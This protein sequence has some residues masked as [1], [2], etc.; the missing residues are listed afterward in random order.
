MGFADLY[1]PGPSTYSDNQQAIWLNCY[2]EDCTY[3]IYYTEK[4]AY[5]NVPNCY[6]NTH[7]SRPRQNS[8]AETLSKATQAE[9]YKS[10]DRDSRSQVVED[11]I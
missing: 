3:I 9:I 4:Y 6:L 2:K 7:E 5:A 1:L 8:D 10:Y 11:M